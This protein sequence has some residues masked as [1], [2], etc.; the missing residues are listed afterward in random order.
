MPAL[1]I[2][3]LSAQLFTA[4]LLVTSRVIG[5]FATMPL[6]GERHVPWQ[7]KA[8][9]SMILGLLLLPASQTTSDLPSESLVML[10]LLIGRELFVGVIVGYLARLLFAAFQFAVNAIDFQMGLTFMQ[11]LSPGLNVN[12]SVM[13]QFLNTLMMLLFLEL[14]GHHVLLRTLAQTIQAVPLGTVL[15]TGT[16]IDGVVALFSA[17]VAVS[18]QLALPTIMILLLIDTAMGVIGRVVPQLNVFMVA[19]PVKVMVGLFTLSL[20]LPA[21]ASLLGTLLQSLSRDSA[22]LIRMLA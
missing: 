9:I 14:D 10:G 18:F 16:M 22:Q 4:Y 2:F 20:S 3:D 17:F 8:G 11:L 1:N 19:M 15:P 7:S 12:L 13:G 6:F 21:L 5:L